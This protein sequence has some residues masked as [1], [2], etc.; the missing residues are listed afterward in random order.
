[1]PG[2]NVNEEDL[3]DFGFEKVSPQEKTRRVYNVFESVAKNYDLMNDLMSFGVHRLWKRFAVHLAMLKPGARVLDMAGGTGDL[4][5]L[6]YPRLDDNGSIVICDI[7]REMLATGRDRLID[8][9]YFDKIAYVQG[10]G[11]ALPFSDQSFDLVSIAFGLRNITD[12]QRSLVSM[13]DKLKFGGQVIILEFSKVA[14]PLLQKI[15]DRY[16]HDCI[17]LLGKYIARDEDSYRYL[18]ESIRMHPDQETLKGMLE[19][20]GFARVE[21][22]NLSGGIVAIHKGYKL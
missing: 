18:V 19:A 15:Y 4:A 20:A 9:G 17:P 10:N 5:R 11:E 2:N 13:Y 21:Y 3:T 14:T 22:H 6:Y 8:R 12:K 1:M 7:N 16:S